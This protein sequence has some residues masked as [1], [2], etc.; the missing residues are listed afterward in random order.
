MKD[1]DSKVLVKK[2][3]MAALK[4]EFLEARAT[5]QA[6]VRK[7]KEEEVIVDDLVANRDAAYINYLESSVR[8]YQPMD[9]EDSPAELTDFP[10]VTRGSW[11][12]GVSSGVSAG[13]GMLLSGL[14]GG[15]QQAPST[16]SAATGWFTASLTSMTCLYS[17]DYL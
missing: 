13:G 5:Y 11:M 10:T 16:A 2:R 9:S 4:D 1:L 7:V 3:E 15:L 14:H 12:D 8:A 17:K 6:L